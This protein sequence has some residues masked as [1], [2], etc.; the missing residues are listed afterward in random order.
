MILMFACACAGAGTTARPTMVTAQAAAVILT[1]RFIAGFLLV[2]LGGLRS[3]C[4]PIEKGRYR[5]CPMRLS[6]HRTVPGR[7]AAIQILKARRVQAPG[8]GRYILN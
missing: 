7:G 4:H 3:S 6:S 8:S 1:I 5:L 2:M